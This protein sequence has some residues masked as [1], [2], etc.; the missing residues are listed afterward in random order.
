MSRAKDLLETKIW[1]LE[2]ELNKIV[3]N[4]EKSDIIRHIEKLRKLKRKIR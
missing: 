4:Q 3:D 1:I 2:E